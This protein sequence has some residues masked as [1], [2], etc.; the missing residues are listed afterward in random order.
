[1]MRYSRWKHVLST[2]AAL[3]VVATTA[4]ATPILSEVYYDAVGSDDGQIFVEIFGTA[5]TLLDG[6]VL[7]GING[8]NGAAGPTIGLSGVIGETGLFV[9]ADRT[10]GGTSSV[11]SADLLANF[12]FQNGPDSVVLRRDGTIVDALGYG[13]FGALDFFAGE[14]ASAPDVSAGSSLAR[15]FANLDS[16][17]NLADFIVLSS[18]TPGSAMMIGLGLSGLAVLGGRQP[19]RSRPTLPLAKRFISRRRAWQRKS[20]GITPERVE[21]RVPERPSF[22]TP[23]KS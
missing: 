23:R 1:M 16:D 21:R 9:V 18:P 20:I 19:A 22:W 10:S 12:D 13:V 17:D 7:E 15:R 5:G 11:A 8:S 14:G 2:W 6:Y 3:G 4:S